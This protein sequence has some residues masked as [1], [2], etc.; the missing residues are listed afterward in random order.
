MGITGSGTQEDWNWLRAETRAAATNF[1]S[2]LRSLQDGSARV[3]NLDWTVAQLGAHLASLPEL[4][5]TQN[6]LAVFEP[7]PDWARFSIDAAAPITD[8][9]TASLADQ[10]ETNTAA[11][12]DELG[13]DPSAARTLYGQSTTAGWAAGGLLSEFILHGADLGGLTGQKCRLGRRQAN[14]AIP[15]MMVLAPTF[16]D[17]EKAKGLDGTYGLRFRGGSEWTY[18]LQDGVLTVTEGRPSKADAHISA[19]AA[20]FIRVALG[21]MNQFAPALTGKVVVWGRKP[22]RM[23]Q[24]G[25]IAVD[26][27]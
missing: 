6:E 13:S 20:A 19:D 15:Q 16:V 8:R 7:P 27:V 14:A 11:F 23:L 25:D 5:R 21:R 2:Q 9:G 18:V 22:W 26:G 10:V 3:S 4:Y 12:I 17:P 24:L 1:A